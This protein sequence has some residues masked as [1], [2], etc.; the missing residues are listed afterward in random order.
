MKLSFIDFLK[1]YTTINQRFIKDFYKFFNI[2]NIELNSLFVINYELLMKWLDLKSKKGF[3]ET[4]QNSYK[5]NVDYIIEK[6][7]T[8]KQGGHNKKIYILT[9]DAAK[10]YCL[11][12]KSSKGESIRDYFLQLEKTLYKYQNYIIKG[13][14]EKIKKLENNQKPKVNPTKGIIYVIRA[15]NNNA[16]LY[17][18]GK[19]VNL[20]N[21]MKLYNSGLSDD[22]EIVLVYESDDIDR[23][24]KCIKLM[25]KPSQYRKYKEIYQVDLDIIKKAINNCDSKLKEINFEIEKQNNRKM[26][27]GSTKKQKNLISKNDKLFMVIPK[28]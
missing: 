16:T 15:L 6:P 9:T 26:K 3:V 12:T 23:L 22:A 25:M 20:K 14:E 17:K 10:R 19:T 18:L 13:L 27:G 2:T 4:L 7:T 28:Y 8:N 21:R 11:M 1:K 5:I 24:E